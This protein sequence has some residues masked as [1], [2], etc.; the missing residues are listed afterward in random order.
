MVQ[1]HGSRSNDQNNLRCVHFHDMISGC[2]A[3]GHQT[4]CP[5]QIHKNARIRTSLFR[6]D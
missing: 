4:L 5:F 1:V 3:N 2:Q 6:Q